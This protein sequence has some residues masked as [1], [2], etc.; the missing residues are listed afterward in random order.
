M[1]VKTQLTQHDFEAILS[2]YNLGKCIRWEAINQGTVQTNYFLETLQGRFVLRYY[3]N[4][5][6]QS[7][8]FESDLLEFLNGKRYPCPFPVKDKQ[9]NC[10]NIYGN[11][12]FMI[13][14]FIEGEFVRQPK[15]YHWQQLIQLAAELQKISSD[16]SSPY[17]AYRWNYDAALCRKLAQDKARQINT[18]SAH[19]KFSWLSRQLEELDLSESLPKAICHC[20]FHFSNVLFNGNKLVALLDFDDANYTFMQFDLV[21]LIEYWAWEDTAETLDLQKARTVVQEYMRHRPLP[22]IEQHHLFDVYKLS[23]L[24]D[25]V[26]YF[27]RG[28]SA[29]FREKEKIEALNRMGREKFIAGLFKN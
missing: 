1:A 24:F 5:S 8:L 25:C 11:K 20:D 2:G 14:K 28:T 9:G 6:K 15:V 13:F 21:G 19:E 17:L 7:V 22:A 3:E 23:I 10:V 27:E 29:H 4:R 12:P 26:W 18:G 16:F